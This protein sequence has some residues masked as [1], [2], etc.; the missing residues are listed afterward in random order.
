[1]PVFT[2]KPFRS[3]AWENSIAARYRR[4]LKRHPFAL[5]GLPFILTVLAGAVFLTPGQALRYERHDRK[6]RKM[7]QEEAMGLQK[8]RR[9]VDMNDEYYRLMS[10]DLDNWE[11]KRVERMPGESENLWDKPNSK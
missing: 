10:K 5:F 9:S 2:S 3:S 8:D 6:V 1:M 11:Q 7:S 4:Q